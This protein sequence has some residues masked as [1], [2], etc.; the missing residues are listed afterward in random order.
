M[1]IIVTS[2]FAKDVVKE[3]SQQ[4]KQE[5]A[6]ILIRISEL[7]ML[8]E[9]PDCKKLKG[10]KNAY[11]IRMG[12]YRIGFLWEDETVKLSRVLNRKDVYKYFP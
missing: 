1:N 10:F 4:Q 7:K 2:K 12:N 3:L 6:K 9:L 8:T 5:L 11:R